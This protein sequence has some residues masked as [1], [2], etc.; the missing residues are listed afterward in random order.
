ML[1]DAQNKCYIY[2]SY[3]K[4]RVET[5]NNKVYNYCDI[6]DMQE[7]FRTSGVRKEDVL[8]DCYVKGYE[9]A[10]LRVKSMTRNE[11][12]LF[13]V[14]FMVVNYYNDVDKFVNEKGAIFPYTDA[15]IAWGNKLEYTGGIHG[16]QGPT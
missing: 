11:Q 4:S 5:F 12:G 16:K 8:L 6:I 3:G 2:N 10:D 1:Y 15:V 13:K 9:Y 7:F 14:H